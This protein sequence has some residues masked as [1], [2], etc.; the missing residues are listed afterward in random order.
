MAR[1]IATDRKLDSWETARLFGLLNM[2]MTDGYIGTFQ[3]KYTYNFWR[4]V[5]AIH[6]RRRGRQPTYHR[7]SELGAARD[8]T[9]H[10]R[11]R[12][13]PQR[14]RWRC[15]R[16]HAARVRNRP[17]RVRGVQLDAASRAADSA[18]T[19]HR[20]PA[21]SAG[22]PTP[23]RRTGNPAYSSG[24]TSATPSP[25]GSPTAARSAGGSSVTTWNRRTTEPTGRATG[26]RRFSNPRA[27]APRSSVRP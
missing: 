14:R 9:A 11:P 23:R 4:P 1:A 12:L 18:T 19:P 15:R 3:E 25:T 17:D 21:R 22:S 24:S 6:P 10:P 2:G 7:R 26:R 13:R 8:D 20:S 27:S 5:T 16:H